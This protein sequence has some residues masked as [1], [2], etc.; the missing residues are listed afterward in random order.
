MLPTRWGSTASSNP[1][2]GLIWPGKQRILPIG[3][4]FFFLFMISSQTG[5]QAGCSMLTLIWKYESGGAAYLEEKH[6]NW[7][8]EKI[9]LR[10]NLCTRLLRPQCNEFKKLLYIK[11]DSKHWETLNWSSSESKGSDNFGRQASSNMVDYTHVWL[12]QFLRKF[13]NRTLW[14]DIGLTFSCPS[15]SLHTYVI[16][17][18]WLTI[19]SDRRSNACSHITFDKQVGEYKRSDNLWLAC[20]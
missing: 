17:N 19:Q 6:Q 7:F 20:V 18:S 3:L 10:Q 16:S 15:K 5:P 13:E 1:S 14:A 4:E 8:H 11:L 9:G 2:T 12:R